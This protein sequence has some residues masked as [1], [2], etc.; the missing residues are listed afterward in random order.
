MKKKERIERLEIQINT[1]RVEQDVHRQRLQ[2]Q[3]IEMED[4][5]QRVKELTTPLPPVD[6]DGLQRSLQEKLKW[7]PVYK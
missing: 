1:L 5:R 7:G 4:L 2:R 3:M 6:G